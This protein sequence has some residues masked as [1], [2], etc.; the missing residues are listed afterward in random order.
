MA[1]QDKR[2]K[3]ESLGQRR[4][5]LARAG[6]DAAAECLERA[7]MRVLDRNARL[8][9]GEIDLVALDGE[10]LVFVEVKLRADLDSA[11]AAVDQRKRKQVSRVAVEWLARHHGLD[12]AARFDVVAVEGGS[13]KCVH[14]IDA[15]DCASE[16]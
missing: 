7:G 12:R 8:T 6:E 5:R 11:L 14:V 10:E 2:Q 13:L 1:G 4:L 16:D 9:S 15:F 3:A